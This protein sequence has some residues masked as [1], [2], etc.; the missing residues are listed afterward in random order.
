MRVDSS[1]NSFHT[2]SARAPIF[3]DTSDTNFYVN[4]ASESVMAKIQ[5]K[6]NSQMSG[7]TYMTFKSATA[8]QYGSI[9][10]SYG[11]M[12]YGTSSDY[13]LK[14]NVVS[15][16]NASDRLNQLQPKR[17]NF[18]EYSDVTVDGFIAHEVAE[19]VPEA[20]VGEKDAIDHHGKPILQSVDHSKLVPLLTASLQEA[21]AKIEDLETRLSLLEQ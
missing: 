19:V 2:A 16:S 1:G 5:V 11:T 9:Y 21:L 3:Y 12:V 20:V 4:P 6:E 14:E 18:I 17:F 15:L 13:R 10:R 8:T 7:Y